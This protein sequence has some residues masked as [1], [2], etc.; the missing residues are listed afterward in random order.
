MNNYQEKIDTLYQRFNDITPEEIKEAEKLKDF[1][2]GV[3]QEKMSKWRQEKIKDIKTSA[4]DLSDR[5]KREL[6]EL[7]KKV[8]AIKYPLRFSVLSTDRTN[9]ELQRLNAFQFLNNVKD[10]KQIKQEIETAISSGLTDYANTFIDILDANKPNEIDLSKADKQTIDFYRFIDTVKK[11][12]ERDNKIS[13][14]NDE[15]K[16]LKLSKME[17]EFLLQNIETE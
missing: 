16:E 10:F 9:G 5:I 1:V 6:N 15:I 12:V 4:S 13:G 17:L 7:I 3:V 2:P 14:I 11:E 8:P